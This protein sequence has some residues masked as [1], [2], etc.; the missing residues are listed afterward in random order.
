M[1]MYHQFPKEHWRHLRT[2]NVVEPPFA[3][4]RLRTTALKHFK[5]V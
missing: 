1:L 3:P 5:K 2:T 4:M